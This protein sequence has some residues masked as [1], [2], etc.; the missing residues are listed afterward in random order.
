VGVQLE[1][2][3]FGGPQLRVTE[4]LPEPPGVEGADP[5]LG[6][7]GALGFLDRAGDRIQQAL[8]GSEVVQQHAVAGADG[9]GQLAQAHVGDPVA[10]GLRYGGGKQPV[11][12][13]RCCH[14]RVY[15]VVHVPCG[16]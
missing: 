14:A 9:R 6:H 15:H 13:L 1:E 8:P 7:E 4:V 5:P 10:H 16:T 2:Q 12:R 3:A 11:T